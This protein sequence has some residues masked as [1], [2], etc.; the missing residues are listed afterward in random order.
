M[1]AGASAQGDHHKDDAKARVRAVGRLAAAASAGAPQG[2]GVA[3]ARALLRSNPQ[4]DACCLSEQTG[5]LPGEAALALPSSHIVWEKMGGRLQG[6]VTRGEDICRGIAKMK[7]LSG[8][9]MAL[10]GRFLRRAATLL[11][12]FAHACWHFSRRPPAATLEDFL[13]QCVAEPWAEISERLGRPFGQLT[14]LDYATHNLA[15]RTEEVT[16]LRLV[17]SSETF[18]HVKP[19][20]MVF[21]NHAEELLIL[22]VVD[23]QRT[24]ANTMNAVLHAQES[25]IAN[26]AAGV[27]RQLM[28]V[29]EHVDAMSACLKVVNADPMGRA[30][31]DPVSYGKTVA[32]LTAGLPQDDA[33]S[34]L[35]GHMASLIPALGVAA[36][37]PTPVLDAVLGFT[38]VSGSSAEQLA[39]LHQ[40]KWT[41]PLHARFVDA[42]REVSIRD[43]VAASGDAGL[44]ASFDALVDG[45]AGDGGYLDTH[46]QL[47]HAYE[48]IASLVN[49]TSLPVS[50]AQ[51]SLQTTRAGG[52][53]VTGGLSLPDES[54]EWMD[55]CTMLDEARRERLEA[56]KV[57]PT[58]VAASLAQ[59]AAVP[60]E[61]GESKAS[62]LVL[63][64]AD[65]GLFYEVG[66]RCA[67]LAQNE[68]E[69]ADLMM[70]ALGVHENT[71]VQLNERWLIGLAHRRKQP[72]PGNPPKLAI[73]DFL[74]ASVLSPLN[75]HVI[76]MLTELLV[77]TNFNDRRAVEDIA[78]EMELW[79]VF[80]ILRQLGVDLRVTVV[81][82]LAFLLP[83]LTSRTYSICAAAQDDIPKDLH[84]TVGKSEVEDDDSEKWSEVMNYVHDNLYHTDEVSFQ[85]KNPNFPFKNP[86]LRSGILIFY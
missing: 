3:P 45:Y 34:S 36:G 74:D 20:F 7:L 69:M 71:F 14:L 48:E 52:V 67:V 31:C 12:C 10:P 6:M 44:Q 18:L 23:L 29:R 19:A 55:M 22:S 57:G 39:K 61:D 35:H 27:Q 9:E 68:P 49:P 1:G 64:V 8:S 4:D 16:H 43:F 11:G 78:S 21:G 53:S 83:P 33:F 66:D 38:A 46:R 76:S 77:A 41:P 70:Q 25:V 72:I 56:S 51:P 80:G 32:Q 62:H 13:P 24:L 30:S 15:F 82:H 28:H 86:D 60:S 50:L 85:W 79:K 75:H 65:Q 2:D 5:Y 84:F 47:V 40:Y 73:R 63:N 58:F 17:E 54:G 59:R 81:P 42:L 26:D 37:S